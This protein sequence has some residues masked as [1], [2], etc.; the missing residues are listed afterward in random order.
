M[1]EAHIE[2]GD[3]SPLKDALHTRLWQYGNSREPADLVKSLCGGEFDPTH[4][5][6]YL[7]RKYTDLYAL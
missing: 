6:R 3:L 1:L 5:T 7:R 2:K 4:Y